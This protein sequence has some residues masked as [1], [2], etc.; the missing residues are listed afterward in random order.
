MTSARLTILLTAIIDIVMTAQ[1]Q[2][3]VTGH[4]KAPVVYV[5]QLTLLM[6][7]RNATVTTLRGRLFHHHVA[8]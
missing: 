2:R 7:A 8:T 3:P 4:L 5:R 1:C 6:I